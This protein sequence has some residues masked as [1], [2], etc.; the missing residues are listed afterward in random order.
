MHQMNMKKVDVK[1]G[2][3]KIRPD[4]LKLI[5]SIKTFRENSEYF[6]E[7]FLNS[8]DGWV[9]GYSDSLRDLLEMH[10]S[11][12][13]NTLWAIEGELMMPEYNTKDERE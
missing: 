8:T 3:N 4:I 10:L 7:R 5:E 2:K 9:V 13:T 1:G 11:G 6:H 12:M